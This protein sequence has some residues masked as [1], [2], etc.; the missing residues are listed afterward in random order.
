MTQRLADGP[1]TLEF[2]QPDRRAMFVSHDEP[3]FLY[4]AGSSC[5]RTRRGGDP[6][7]RGAGSYL[8]GLALDRSKKGAGATPGRERSNRWRH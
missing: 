1:V 5:S 4:Y 7:R 8:R 6:S 2:E 3:D